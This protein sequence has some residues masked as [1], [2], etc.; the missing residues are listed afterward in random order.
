MDFHRFGKGGTRVNSKQAA[1]IL[2]T[3]G[4]CVLLLKRSDDSSSAGT[5]CL[6]GG[7][8][9]K[10]ETKIGTAI[11]ETKEETGIDNIPG[12]RFDTITSKDGLKTFTTFLYRVD[13]QF[14]VEDLSDEHTDWKW[15]DLKDM[16]STNLH[17]KLKENL[18][19]Y[20]NAIRRKVSSFSEWVKIRS[21][22]GHTTS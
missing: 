10:G 6:P 15:I 12:R 13:D 11:R 4:N 9:K 16:K 14:E 22:S 8:S 7:G 3:D 19:R 21:I 1:G 18:E 17:P 20:T 5:W 2:F